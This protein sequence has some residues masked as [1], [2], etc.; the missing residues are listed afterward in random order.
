MNFTILRKNKIWKMTE[1]SSLL[2]YVIIPYLEP[3]FAVCRYG[4]FSRDI[5]FH[6][7]ETLVFEPEK[8]QVYDK[9]NRTFSPQISTSMTCIYLL[10]KCFL[11]EVS[12]SSPPLLILAKPTAHFVTIIS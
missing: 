2:Q 6:P 11:F 3:Y 8:S 12:D 1:S 9:E 7:C 4:F 10:A 5:L